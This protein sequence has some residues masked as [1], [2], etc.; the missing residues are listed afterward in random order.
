MSFSREA[1]W[2]RVL[3]AW[4][5]HHVASQQYNLALPSTPIPSRGVRRMKFGEDPDTTAGLRGKVVVT[6]VV[7]PF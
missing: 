7:S 5:S 2:Y 1:H 6:E 4:K 3:E